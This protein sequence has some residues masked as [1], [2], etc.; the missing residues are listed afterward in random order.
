MLEWKYRKYLEYGLEQND[1]VKHFFVFNSSIVAFL[2]STISVSY[3]KN[4]KWNKAGPHT[5]ILL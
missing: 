2:L 4:G 3:G 1:R 5:T